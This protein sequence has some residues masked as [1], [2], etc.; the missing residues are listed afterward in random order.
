MDRIEQYSAC[1][2]GSDVSARPM[3]GYLGPVKGAMIEL[4]RL[5][6]Y[7]ALY[8]AEYRVVKGC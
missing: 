3:R 2:S 1:V 6:G 4:S 8:R 7:I 5:Q